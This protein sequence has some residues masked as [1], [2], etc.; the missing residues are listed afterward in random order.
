MKNQDI[1]RIV[2]IPF[3]L[4]T[5]LIFF[6]ILCIPIIISIIFFPKSCG[7]FVK[8]IYETIYEFIINGGE[9]D[10]DY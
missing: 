4:A 10:N 9:K 3:R 8:D 5:F 2:G 1:V 6:P 7:G